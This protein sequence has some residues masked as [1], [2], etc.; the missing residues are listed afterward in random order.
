VLEKIAGKYGSTHLGL[1]TQIANVLEIALT[2]LTLE[3]K[4]MHAT[5]DF[6]LSYAIS[7]QQEK[8][9]KPGARP[10]RTN[11]KAKWSS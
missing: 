5:F 11:R 10:V 4:K 3:R 1:I 2:T 6:F 9:N 8:C 7:H